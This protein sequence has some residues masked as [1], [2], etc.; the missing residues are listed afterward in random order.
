VKKRHGIQ[1]GDILRLTMYYAYF[2]RQLQGIR[3]T[4]WL[5]AA[6]A[7]VDHH[8]DMH[9]HCGNWCR[10]KM[11]TEQERSQSLKKYRCK[12][13]NPEL[14]TLLCETIAPFITLS[15]LQELGHGANTNVNESLN[16]TISWF[17]P[18]NRTSLFAIM[19]E[20]LFPSIWSAMKSSMLIYVESWVFTLIR[21][22][23]IA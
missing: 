1:D 3:E 13:T 8:F 12:K 21:V 5:E 16:Q 15:C 11:E 18:K 7:I 10:R 23:N 17:A 22:F 4:E 9:D 20:W 14:Y 19:S 2:I 6:K